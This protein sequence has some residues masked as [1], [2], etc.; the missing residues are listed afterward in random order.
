[1]PPGKAPPS[2]VAGFSFLNSPSMLQSCGRLS[3]RQPA[4][5]KLML[6]PLDTSP[7]LKCQPLSK[8]KVDRGCWLN[9]L[10]AKNILKARKKNTLGIS[11]DLV[12]SIT[13]L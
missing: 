8:L 12:K 7:K 11:A 10:A 13:G 2:G 1:M 5:L 6:S 3:T 4:S 9:A